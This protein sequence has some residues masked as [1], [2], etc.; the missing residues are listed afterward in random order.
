MET[1]LQKKEMLTEGE[2]PTLTQTEVIANITPEEAEIVE[3]ALHKATNYPPFKTV[4]L[5]ESLD[6]TEA[7]ID[8]ENRVI[9][10]VVLIREGMSLNRRYY[11]SDTL[12]NAVSVFENSS[13]Y[14]DH[15]QP[16][17]KVPRNIRDTTGWYS[18][19]R[20][21]E[22]KLIADRY[23]TKNQ[24]GQ[25]V[26]S[27]AEDIIAG[28]APVTLAGL[29][30]NA[31]GGGRVKKF[32][33]GEALQVES[34]TKAQSVDDITVPAAGGQ[35]MLTA[36]AEDP[37]IKAIFDGLT[38][39]EW[40]DA[41][42]EYVE[43]LLS[44][45][46]QVRLADETK[47][48]L[49]EADQKVKAAESDAGQARQELTEAQEEKQTLSDVNA[50]LL[51]EVNQARRE[52]ALEKALRAARLPELYEDDLR[53]QL[54]PLPITEWAGRIAIEQTKAART[55]A[56][57]KVEVTGAGAQVNTPVDVTES[58][59]DTDWLLPRANENF[60]DWQGRLARKS[61]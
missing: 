27:I 5:S 58:V 43:K 44:A 61:K 57:P 3:D 23:F 31:V 22:G 8:I 13:A 14:A 11:P 32:D 35:Y 48:K 40:F 7:N 21:S 39:Q 37:L 42:P 17:S 41:R 15:P 34:I 54:L 29:S 30:I 60:A 47:A 56:K 33:D 49:A 28:R 12:R 45:H 46:K 19:V 16:G 9:R 25:D 26:F 1:T 50:K 55:H 4:I 6:L 51:E 59:N 38:Y 20:F 10:D 2:K 52:L 24:A 53:K 18:N 36:S